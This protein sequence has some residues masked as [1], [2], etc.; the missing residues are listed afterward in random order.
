MIGNKNKLED[1]KKRL[2]DWIWK[3]A[4]NFDERRENI[5]YGEEDESLSFLL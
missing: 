2:A 4:I 3:E 5:S 1:S